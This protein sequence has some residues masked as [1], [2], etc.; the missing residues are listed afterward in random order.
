MV[1][2]PDYAGDVAEENGANGNGR[3]TTGGHSGKLELT[4]T[5][6]G[7]ALLADEDGSYEWVPRRDR[8]VAEVRLLHDA[9]P[10]GEVGT[11]EDRVKDNLLI[12]GDSL[13]ALIA[14][15]KLP[16]FAAEYEGKVKLCYIDPPF[17]TGQ[18][19][20]HYDDGLEHSVWLTMMRDRLVEI[21][22]LLSP[23]GSIWVHLD[24]TEMAHCK[25][26]LDEVFGPE[27][28]VT[29]VVWEKRYSRSND[30][31][32]SSSHDYL[33]VYSPAGDAYKDIRNRIERTAAQA[34]VYRD[35]GDPNGPWR[36]IPFDAPN[37][38]PNLTYPI[39]T[40]SG[41]EKWP[42]KGR[43]WSTTED[44][45]K[46]I[47]KDGLAYFGKKGNG[48]PNVKR[49]LKDDP[50]IV[51]NTWWP[52]EETGNNDEAKKEIQALFPDE[53]PFDTPKPERLMRRIIQIATDP[54]EIVLDCFAGSGTT[55]AVAHK[56]GRRWV[57][58]EARRETIDT[59]TAPRLRRVVEGTD[60]GGITSRKTR[61]AEGELP[62]GVSA[63]DAQRFTTLLGKFADSVDPVWDEEPDGDEAKKKAKLEK[64][65][66]EAQVKALRAAAKTR[67][68]TVVEWEGGGGF[69]VL[70]VG[71]SMYEEDAGTVVLAEWAVNGQLQEAVA[72]QLGFAYEP[73]GLFSGR[74]GRMRLGVVDGH[75]TNELADVF[76]EMLGDGERLTLCALSLDPE[77]AQR[78][79]QARAG[80]RVRI[81]PED[82]LLAY[83][84]ASPR[85]VSVAND[86]EVVEAMADTP[87]GH[88]DETHA[89][90]AA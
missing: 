73:D 60:P 11:D 74:K 37:I 85:R 58:I 14:L 34:E 44:N 82:L 15:T 75:A 10:V 81:V 76:L 62:E 65:A 69:R 86:L 61:V 51:P 23:Q 53:T 41:D 79:R 66:V 64:K 22:K 54:G 24:D 47:V 36:P 29:T 55:A 7:K 52:H 72:A 35:D 42:P 16:E 5:N 27:A 38:R 90:A 4:W 70:D 3:K 31:T 59:F 32:F 71:P 12:R 46:K 33:L 56:M 84:T 6:K 39:I 40:P 43:C 8:R 20:E 18:T 1:P 89:E 87:N 57:T 9:G 26:L 30:A 49:Y 77:V 63:E 25:A 78:L 45:W 13:S 21:K 28:F 83:A 19:F 2:T 50:G 48:M 67:E 17:N 88:S 80:S 68:K